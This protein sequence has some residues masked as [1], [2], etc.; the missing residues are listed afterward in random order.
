M[1]WTQ[2]RVGCYWTSGQ[3]RIST[4]A[5][6]CGGKVDRCGY[7]LFHKRIPLEDFSYLAYAQLAAIDHERILQEQ[8]V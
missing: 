1:I 2:D 6:I 5:E 4:F 3:Y 7:R 8:T